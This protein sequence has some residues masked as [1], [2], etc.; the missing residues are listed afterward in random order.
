MGLCPKCLIKSGFFSGS[1]SASKNAFAPPSVEEL[2]S[3]LPQ[4]EVL[5]LIGR[6]GMGAVYKARQPRL[7]RHVALKV[8]ARSDDPQFVERFERE[9]RALGRMTHPNIV[10]VYDF[11]ETGGY[12]YLIMELVDGLNLRQ[13]QQAGRIPPEQALAIVP[14]ICEALEYAH[15]QGIVHRDIKPENILLDRNGHVKIADF[16][17][18]KILGATGPDEPL[19][20]A[21][22]AVGTPHYMAPE[23]VEKPKTVDH[24][25][26]I[27]SLGVVLYEMLTGELP[28]GRFAPPSKKVQID[29]RLDEIV[30]RALEKEPEL[31][32]Q[33]ASELQ[34]RVEIVTA[35]VGAELPPSGSQSAAQAAQTA[36]DVGPVSRLA[37]AGVLWAALYFLRQLLFALGV[38]ENVM[39]T[40]PTLAHTAPVGA[41]ILGIIAAWR[42]GRSR[43]QITGLPLAIYAAGLFPALGAIVWLTGN[44]YVH[45]SFYNTLGQ[46]YQT[47]GLVEAFF[48]ALTVLLPFPSLLG[49]M[50]TQLLAALPLL[51]ATPA[52]VAVLSRRALRS[53]WTGEPYSLTFKLADV[54]KRLWILALLLA[55]EGMG[56]LMA[57]ISQGFT[58]TGMAAF[59]WLSFKLLAVCGIFLRWKPVFIYSLF[60]MLFHV[61]AFG[62]VAPVVAG[63]NLLLFL[64]LASA[65]RY[66]F[67]PPCVR[68]PWQIWVA[69]LWQIVSGTLAG[70]PF[71]LSGHIVLLLLLGSA[72][73]P[74]FRDP[75]TRPVEPQLDRRTRGWFIG[76]ALFLCALFVIA[77]LA[78]VFQPDTRAVN[79]PMQ[80]KVEALKEAAK[81][82]YEAAN[83]KL[84]A[85]KPVA[86]AEA[87]IIQVRRKMVDDAISSA[88]RS[89]ADMDSLKLSGFGRFDER[90]DNTRAETV[91]IPSALADE[92]ISRGERLLAQKSFAVSENW[93]PIDA[94]LDVMTTGMGRMRGTLRIVPGQEPDGQSRLRDLFWIEFNNPRRDS[95]VHFHYDGPPPGEGRSRVFLVHVLV[96][97][98][99]DPE[100]YIMVDLRTRP[101][102]LAGD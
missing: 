32:F 88:P 86:E 87:R 84:P 71:A 94:T 29:V 75:A 14:P 24:R 6:G 25:A 67:T 46:T 36:P 47:K 26:D 95:R 72:L 68:T 16:G 4:L 76:Y 44:G 81:Q 38:S 28:L 31:R 58:A 89:I 23:Q 39:P 1:Q 20:G 51:V 40:I 48:F 96:P 101:A 17:I 33:H 85:G 93:T 41:T 61:A 2:N 49:H 5:E 100:R 74:Y 27:Y 66:Y 3:L 12:C 79:Q 62:Q 21:L 56:N 34:T 83:L 69:L 9:A 45:P 8:L 98:E 70:T 15:K 52:V 80:N 91:E 73:L 22:Q 18:A 60:I 78:D 43:G 99:M 57:V 92:L 7:D 37:I 11:G 65:Y 30:L 63:L 64:L 77:G 90:G 53:G 42:I 102:A 50:P 55:L 59:G 54:P 97:D 10:G 19:T 82:R 13:L 35:G